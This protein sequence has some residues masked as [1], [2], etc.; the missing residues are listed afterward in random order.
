MILPV[1][2]NAMLPGYCCKSQ[3]YSKNHTKGTGSGLERIRAGSYCCVK[4][5]FG[6]KNTCCLVTYIFGA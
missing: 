5:I 1:D 4:N 2:Q 3:N 6:A